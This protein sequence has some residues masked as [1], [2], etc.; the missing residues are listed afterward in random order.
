MKS[1]ITSLLISGTLMLL[2]M[3]NYSCANKMG[4][5][6]TI[7]DFKILSSQFRE[8]PAEY[9]TA[10]FFVWNGEI[11]RSEIDNFLDEFYR[12]GIKQVFIHPRPGLITEYLCDEWFELFRYTVD[13]GKEL[14]MKVWIYDEN[15]YP[16]GFAGG[17]VPAEMPESYNEGQGLRMIETETLPDTADKFFLILKE[18]DGFFIDV[19]DSIGKE[20]EKQGKYFLFK[21]TYYGKSEWY[22]GFSYVDLLHP[23]VTE[24]FIELTMQ[25]YEKYAIEEFGKTILGTF[26]DEPHINTPGGIRFTPDLFE[27]FMKMWN[28]D[29]KT[30]LPSL[31]KETGDWKKV[32]HNYT[33]TLLQMFIDRWSKPWKDYCDKKGLKFTGHYWEHEWPSMRNGGDNMAMYAWH[34]I[35]GIDMLFN[36]WND[37]SSRA[38]F[39]NIRSVKE[40][41]S[42]ANQAGWNRKLSE[43]YGGSGWD[44]TFKEM[45][46]NGDWEYALGVNLMNQHL[47]FF[48]M[49]GARKY[50][51]PPTF[52]YHEPWWNNYKILADHYARLSLALSAGKQVNEILVIEP[53]TT[54]WLYDSYV[55]PNPYLDK[56]GQSFQSF[57]THLEKMQVEYDLGS[58]NIISNLGS[59]RKGKFIIGNCEYKTIIIPPAIENFNR[60]TFDLLKN[61][62]TGGGKLILFSSPVLIDGSESSELKEWLNSQQAY[63]IKCKALT[64]EFV[65]ETLA[66]SNVEFTAIV[67]MG[68]YHHTRVLKDGIL[69]FLC[70]SNLDNN[71]S[72]TFIVPGVS[73]V[74]L[75][76]I[77]CKIKGYPCERKDKKIEAGFNLY[78]A[79]SL[80]LFFPARKLTGYPVVKKSEEIVTE[81]QPVG[82]ITVTRNEQNALMIDFCDLELKG[83]T[84]TDLHVYNATDKV[85]KHYGFSS[86]NP[87]NHSVQYKTRIVDRDT[88]SSGT[89]FKATYQFIVKGL[90]DR[91][92]L[93]AVVERPHLWKVFLNGT[94]ISPDPD[95]WWLDRSF[96]VFYIS[97]LVKEGKNELTLSVSSM[98]VHAEIEPVYILGDFSVEPAPKG[99][100]ITP[101][102]KELITGTWLNQGLPFYSWGITYLKEYNIDSPSGQYIVQVSDWEGT[103]AEVFVNR[104]KAGI[105]AFLPFESDITPFIS[106]GKNKIEVKITGSLRNLL[107]PH[108]NNPPEGISSP[109]SWRNVKICPSG[110]EYRLYDY[111]LQSDYTLINRK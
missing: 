94:E 56:I 14:G 38:Q 58:E 30:S 35:P 40:L 79:G 92:S 21:K 36:Q 105:I 22:G 98:N 52:D 87:W 64:D 107:G 5:E 59:V 16:S 85:F 103:V 78:P 84:E 65:K 41:N 73:A 2:M 68:L 110:K 62:V 51:Y 102:T 28:Y 72:G 47:T 3:S 20:K 93:M 46:R 24:K 1:I 25:G 48:T 100:V 57:V 66:N 32:R 44:L 63:I 70:N 18:E 8:P 45:K 27:V 111:G 75:N 76:T 7:P 71:V 19:T 43:T 55:K 95:R 50:D 39:G 33:C 106:A 91:S 12:Q 83:K 10:P 54:A 23:G 108:H 6:I 34:H 81:V 89:G 26:T 74:E 15:S 37:S 53:T 49:A 82:K 67:G 80:L 97:D 96:R 13:R 109:W 99:W 90:K 9:T 60:K 77:D 4:D 17:H 86:G 104:K 61:F 101:P 31:F 69:V 11:T 88:F 42:A 29:L